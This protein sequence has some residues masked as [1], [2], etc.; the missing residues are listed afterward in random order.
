M[1][2]GI[3]AKAF[4]P[5]FDKKKVTLLIVGEGG[6]GKTSLACQMA[7]WAMAE[8]PEQRLCKTHQMLPVLI[9]A[10]LDTPHR[11]KMYWLKRAWRSE[12][13]DWRAG[14]DL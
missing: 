9:E 11:R 13:V 7:T 8:E 6:A 5:I 3:S 2:E 12:R 4:Q 14:A 1:H 10:N